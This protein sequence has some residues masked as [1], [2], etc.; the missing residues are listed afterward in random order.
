MWSKS[1]TSGTGECNE[2]EE[3]SI[4]F[5]CTPSL[6]HLSN[7]DLIITV[8]NGIHFLPWH[9][10]NR[11]LIWFWDFFNWFTGLLVGFPLFAKEM[12]TWQYPPHQNFPS[13][14]PCWQMQVNEKRTNIMKLHLLSS[15]LQVL[16]WLQ[17]QQKCNK[18]Q[19]W[20]ITAEISEVLDC[21]GPG[22]H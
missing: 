6:H 16:R 15:D 5:P 9:T 3:I 14:L 1:C 17:A 11:F 21:C 2:G 18:R 20:K 22:Q 10:L 19:R 7:N 8:L 4:D 12:E 13:L